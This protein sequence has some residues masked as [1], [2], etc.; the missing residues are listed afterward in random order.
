MLNK[1]LLIT[2]LTFT[3]N[4]KI[5]SANPINFTSHKYP[6]NFALEQSFLK[7]LQ[8]IFDIT[9]FVETGTYYAHTT[10]E[11][12]SIFSSIHT[13]ELHPVLAQ[14]AK[15]MFANQHH[16]TVHWGSSPEIFTQ[17]LPSLKN[18]GRILFFLDAH[19]SG[20]DTVAGPEGTS[21]ADGI[22]AIRKEITAIKESGIQDC[23]IL[24]DDI[25]GFGTRT[26]GLEFTGCWAYPPLQDICKKLLEI[27][28]NFES[29]LIGD[30]LL[31]Y[32]KTKHTVPLS[33][34]V[35]ACTMSRLF[36]GSN[37][38]EQE[39]LEAERTIALSQGEERTFIKT[40]CQSMNIYNDPEFHHQLWYGLLAIGENK[41]NEAA[42][43]F[44][45]VLKRSY[46]HSRLQRYAEQARTV[47]KHS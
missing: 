38:S 43:A 33:P 6:Y 1:Y 13:I 26:E 17:L 4:C 42:Q 11:A 12:A 27:N 9:I 7:Q 24:I 10:Q 25:R 46:K 19:Y 47:S 20:D 22:T 23:V 29:M 18:Q 45:K 36:D 28:N 5:F 3:L 39:L 40:L 8:E 15:N 32:D 35:K 41:L 44:D 31:T 34:M 37:Y 2:L 30:I 21:A 16:I 14:R